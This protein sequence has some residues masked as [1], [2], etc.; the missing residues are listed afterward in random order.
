MVSAAVRVV[1]PWSTCP[2][3]PMLTWG[4]LRSNLPRAA[5]TV[6]DRRLRAE[7]E[8]GKDMMEKL[9][10]KE[11]EGSVNLVGLGRRVGFESEAVLVNKAE[12]EGDGEEYGR[13][14][15]E[16]VV[17]LAAIEI[18]MVGVGLRATERERE[19]ERGLRMGG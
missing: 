9:V 1:L 17:A 13:T 7:A 4:F 8:G 16:E 15:L 6:K 19:R 11:A 2:M 18:A 10:M 5:R 3:V 12:E 14:R